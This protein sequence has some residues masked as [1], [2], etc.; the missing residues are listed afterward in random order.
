MNWQDLALIGIIEADIIEMSAL[1]RCS[2][3]VERVPVKDK[4]GGPNPPAGA[5]CLAS[6]NHIK[7]SNCK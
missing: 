4:V 6:N 3:V 7:M 2:S 5:N 1:I